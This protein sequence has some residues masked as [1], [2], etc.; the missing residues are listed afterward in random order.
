MSFVREASRGPCV[1][2]VGSTSRIEPTAD[3]GVRG[4][5][6]KLA[7]E[8]TPFPSPL[9]YHPSHM[10]STTANIPHD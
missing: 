1:A 7:E 3:D 2:E 6:K 5:Q 10:P 8:P 4:S 9:T